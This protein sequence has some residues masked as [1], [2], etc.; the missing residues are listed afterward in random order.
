MNGDGSRF[1]MHVLC[2]VEYWNESWECTHKGLI[3]IRL[4]FIAEHFKKLEDHSLLTS[5]HREYLIFSGVLVR[6]Y[7]Q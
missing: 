7:F 3:I 1:M 6:V 2:Q 5:S 4:N